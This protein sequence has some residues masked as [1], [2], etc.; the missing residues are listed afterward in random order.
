[1]RQPY[2][3]GDII[4]IDVIDAEPGVFGPAAVARP[5]RVRRPLPRWLLPT[6]CGVVA[7]C[8][9]VAMVWRP[10]EHPPD[11]RT[12]EPAT[13]AVSSMSD[14]L[15]LDV[16]GLE[17]TTLH[18]GQNLD[19]VGPTVA[20]DSGE[21]ITTSAQLIGSGT[22]ADGINWKASTTVGNP[23]LICVHSLTEE[24]T[25]DGSCIYTTPLSPST[26]IVMHE[27][28]GA[29]F[30]TAM[31]PTGDQVLR[32]S[33]ASGHFEDVDPVALNAT[34][35]AAAALLP[36]GATYELLDPAALK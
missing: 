21:F 4:E 29:T 5:R 34:S 33:Y 3:P 14:H 2:G 22:A 6:A 11:W 30:V 17:V 18:E 23:T 35:E 20:S 28:L 10:W 26:H 19:A 24:G 7:V 25:G 32:I 16:E 9:T 15:I 13:P 1:M 12:F 8:G 27:G 36:E 31:M